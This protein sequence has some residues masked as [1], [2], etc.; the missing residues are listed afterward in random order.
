MEEP[1]VRKITLRTWIA[2]AAADVVLW[3][4]AN[5][6]GSGYLAFNATGAFLTVLK[7]LWVASLLAFIV[8]LVLGV[9][10]LAT[11]RRRSAGA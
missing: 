3:I 2:L 8:L 7:V 11:S 10:S 9:V 4:I 5:S 1:A 6:Q